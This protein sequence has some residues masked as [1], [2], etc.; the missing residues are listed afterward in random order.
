[1]GY[2]TILGGTTE[3]PL[4]CIGKRAGICWGADIEDEEKNVK[5]AKKC[6]LSGHGRVLEYVDIE[7]VINGYSARVMREFER[8]HIGSTFLQES[9][10]YVKMDKEGFMVVPP[11]I[12]KQ[13]ENNDDMKFAVDNYNCALRNL[14]DI[15]EN[16]KVP[17]EDTAMFYPIGMKTK[18]VDKRNLR[19]FT[20]MCGQRLCT[21]A[22]WEYR[23]LMK[24]IINE[25]CK[26]S[27]EWCWIADNLFVPKCEKVGYCIE[28][29]CCGKSH[30]Q[31]E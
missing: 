4:S 7:L 1:M 14:M 29:K 18:I 12:Y 21:R 22:Y 10:R 23:Y 3:K 9:T 26:I 15:F 16:N 30:R 5:R 13:F 28:E 20:E 8:H 11:S 24:D 25:L 2:I 31:G 19:S 6:I 17:Q 27:D